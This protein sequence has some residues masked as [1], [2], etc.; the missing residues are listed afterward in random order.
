MALVLGGGPGNSNR[1]VHQYRAVWEVGGSIRSRR[2]PISLPSTLPNSNSSLPEQARPPK[3]P[4]DQPAWVTYTS[5]W[6]YR[7]KRGGG[8]KRVR[9]IERKAMR[10]PGGRRRRG[11]AH[12]VRRSGRV[13]VLTGVAPKRRAGLIGASWDG[14]E[15]D[16]VSAEYSLSVISQKISVRM[17]AESHSMMGWGFVHLDTL[18]LSLSL[19][20]E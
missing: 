1:T 6:N 16:R 9:E 3:T 18:S 2:I 20:S 17:R 4:D 11:E 19:W 14:H 8:G 15:D 13:V 12:D 5:W 7:H 10:R